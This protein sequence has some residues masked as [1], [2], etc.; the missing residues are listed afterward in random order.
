MTK[1]I[2][3]KEKL[4]ALYWIMRPENSITAFI[5]VIVAM[6]LAIEGEPLE[7]FVYVF[8]GCAAFFTTAQANTHNDI[9]D[10]E[11][12]RINSPERA[13]P[14]GILTMKEAKI[15]A[16]SLFILACF[17]GILIDINLGLYFPFSLFW[18][19]LNSLLL[20]L[21][22]WKFKKNGLFGNFIV[23]YVV[24]A[25]FLY[26]D[27]VVNHSLTRI[28]LIGFFAMQLNWGREVIKGIRDIDGDRKEGIKTIGVLY[29]PKIAAIIGSSLI[30]VGIIATFPLIIY[31]FISGGS[32][33]IPLVLT[34]FDI[35][36]IY[37]LSNLIQNPDPELA[38][39]TK[40]FLLRIML[41]AVL[42]ISVE[43]ILKKF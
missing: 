31:P 37:K 14:S 34:I 27:I 26:A 21:Y 35:I 33:I 13:L 39:R 32:L 19:V 17:S 15:W 12:D 23:G 7:P 1:V 43:Q 10:I 6:F 18:A 16:I 36:L 5:A 2:S 41:I 8:I 30:V 22:N 3:R 25:L 40:R 38:T 4:I 42:T 29:G 11:V 9:I 28:S 20:D 24:G